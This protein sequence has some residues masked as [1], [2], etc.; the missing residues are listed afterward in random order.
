MTGRDE[1]QLHH[2][3]VLIGMRRKA[4]ERFDSDIPSKTYSQ[5]ESWQYVSHRVMMTYVKDDLK[6]DS[7]R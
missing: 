3:Q 5:G 2:Q 1:L 4:A 7:G 6:E